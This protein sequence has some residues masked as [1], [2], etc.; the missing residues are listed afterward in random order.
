MCL[1]VSYQRSLSRQEEVLSSVQL[2]VQQVSQGLGPGLEDLEQLKKSLDAVMQEVFAAEALR[3]H[4]GN[5]T[6]KSLL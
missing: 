6:L 4:I 5:K 1:P 3:E 2:E